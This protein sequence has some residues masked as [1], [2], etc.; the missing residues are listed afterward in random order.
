MATRQRVR[1]RIDIAAEMIRLCSEGKKMTN[2]M[3]GANL[4]YDQ[5]KRYLPELEEQRLIEK[6]MMDGN[7]FYRATHRG[8]N[9]LAA[10]EE[11]V[12]IIR[13]PIEDKS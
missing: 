7:I 12:R 3:Y 6:V 2:I 5:L 11:L 8:R 4:S 1:G 13:S 9:Y 10:Y